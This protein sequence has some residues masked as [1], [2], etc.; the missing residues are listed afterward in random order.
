MHLTPQIK[1]KSFLIPS[2]SAISQRKIML[3]FASRTLNWSP[4]M[5]QRSTS[6]KKKWTSQIDLASTKDIELITSITIGWSS[7]NTSAC[8]LVLWRLSSEIDSK[9][10]KHTRTKTTSLMRNSTTS[11]LTGELASVVTDLL[12]RTMR[13]C[14]GSSKSLRNQTQF[15]WSSSITTIIGTPKT[16]SLI[17]LKA[18]KLR[19][20]AVFKKWGRLPPWE[21]ENL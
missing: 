6:E 13:N 21:K 20:M 15:F 10:R 4:M 9:K 2:E 16:P 14:S 12:V 18:A 7:T 5:C 8:R 3:Y 1:V 19:L 11:S 17:F